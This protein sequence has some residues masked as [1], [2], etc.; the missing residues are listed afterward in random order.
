MNMKEFLSNL[1]SVVLG[2]AITFAVQAIID[3]SQTKKDIRAALEL[4]RTELGTNIDDIGVMTDYLNQ[5]R[6]AARY[7]IDHRHTLDSCP[8]DSVSHHSGILFADASISISSDALELLK[9]S[10]M[11]PKIGDQSLSMKII[12]AYD[13]SQ[14]IAAVL[15]Q[16]VIDRNN[17]FEATINE[18]TA[19]LYASDG[20]ISIRDYI[21]TDYGYYAL[22]RITSLADIEAYADISDIED[23]IAAI[24]TYLKD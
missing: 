21:K 13:T 4:V 8:A 2:I 3:R 19:A 11:F 20:F 22:S 7:F 9:N 15:N 23:A 24:S 10:S 6:A 16:H 1:L 5:E 17:H 12:R 18:K 14:S